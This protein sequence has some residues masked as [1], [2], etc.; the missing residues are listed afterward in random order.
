MKTSHKTIAYYAFV[1]A[2][3]AY[4]S[5]QLFDWH[6]AALIAGMYITPFL[7]GWFEREMDQINPNITTQE[8]EA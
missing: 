7:Y 6:P 1:S 2:A 5:G 8:K 4:I 3:G